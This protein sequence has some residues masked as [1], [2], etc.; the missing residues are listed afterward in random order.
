ML[1]GPLYGYVFGGSA[2]EHNLSNCD[3]FDIYL[4]KYIQRIYIYTHLYR[5]IQYLT[6]NELSWGRKSR[7][8]KHPE[9]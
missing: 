2:K 1:L 3:Q 4:Y 9:Y 7:L 5:D 8:K 6:P